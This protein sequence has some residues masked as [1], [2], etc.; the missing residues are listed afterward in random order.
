MTDKNF[1]AQN[2]TTTKI[3]EQIVPEI[4]QTPQEQLKQ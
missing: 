2:Y 1:V 3:L 4:N